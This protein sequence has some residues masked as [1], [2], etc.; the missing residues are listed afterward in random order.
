MKSP[1]RNIKVGIVGKYT[2]FPDAYKSLSEAIV[3][4]SL[5]NR[6][7]AKI[8]WINSENLKTH[9]IEDNLSELDGI[10]VPGGFGERGIKGK[11]LTIAFARNNNIPFLGICLGLQLAI[12]EFAQNV[13]N[14]KGANS[15]EFG[16]C[17]EPVIGLLTEW[18]K[19]KEK[20]K[21]NLASDKGGTMRLGSYPCNLIKGTV[22]HSIY[23]RNKIQ[24]RHRHRY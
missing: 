24:E 19:G 12:I 16:K 11:L 10:I 7:E 3:H 6:S 20:I 5:T 4:G 18:N 21:R 15:S 22:A 14:L 1:K 23:K 17:E 9:N 8:V 13:L 2:D